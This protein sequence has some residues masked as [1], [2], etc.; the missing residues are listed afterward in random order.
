MG[1][2]I[3]GG[4]FPLSIAMYNE[5]LHKEL[6][7]S[8]WVH[9]HTYSFCLSGVL[10]MLEYLNVLEQYNYMDNVNN[11]IELARTHFENAGWQ[12]IGNY[13][14]TFIL[15]KN[16]NHFRFILPINADQEYFDAI[17]DTLKGL[18]ELWSK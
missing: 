6:K 4:F 13:G 3:T 18:E 14:I 8:N 11:I 1:K 2:A 12:I 7:D 17:P 5:K 15:F 10:S 9:G 16:G